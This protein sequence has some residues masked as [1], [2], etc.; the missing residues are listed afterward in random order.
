MHLKTIAD[1]THLHIATV[2]PDGS[3]LIQL[4]HDAP[5]LEENATNPDLIKDLQ[6]TAEDVPDTTNTPNICCTHALTALTTQAGLCNFKQ[7]VLMLWLVVIIK[8]D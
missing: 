3:C 2:P 5:P 6:A 7:V 4:I 8:S 1:Q